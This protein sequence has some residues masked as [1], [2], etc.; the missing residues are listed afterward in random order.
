MLLYLNIAHFTPSPLKNNTKIQY[1]VTPHK[2]SRQHFSLYS[3]T[4][5]FYE[6]LALWNDKRITVTLVYFF[7]TLLIEHYM[8]WIIYKRLVLHRYNSFESIYLLHIQINVNVNKLFQFLCEKTLY[9]SWSSTYN[10]DNGINFEVIMDQ[11]TL[12][13]KLLVSK[14]N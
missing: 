5:L 4:N 7:F 9:F 10:V 1:H 13:A 12:W 8:I 6:L 14:S 3:K 2:S 11:W